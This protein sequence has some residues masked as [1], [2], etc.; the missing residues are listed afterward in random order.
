MTSIIN[1]SDSGYLNIQITSLIISFNQLKQ[2]VGVMKPSHMLENQLQMNVSVL[3]RILFEQTNTESWLP[4]DITARGRGS[5]LCSVLTG[6][7]SRYVT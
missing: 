7:Q 3:S 1:P 4:V 6:C 5:V 2:D